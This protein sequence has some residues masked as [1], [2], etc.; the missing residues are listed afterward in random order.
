MKHAHSS[1]P[2]RTDDASNPRV[3]RR[4]VIDRQTTPPRVAAVRRLP[5]RPPRPAIQ[6]SVPPRTATR[7]PRPSTGR[8]S[9][10]S[11]RSP[12]GNV[13]APEAVRERMSGELPRPDSPRPT[14]PPDSASPRCRCSATMHPAHPPPPK[15][16]RRC[17]HHP[18]ASSPPRTHATRLG[19]R[20]EP[21][22]EVLDQAN[23]VGEAPASCPAETARAPWR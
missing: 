16:R 17:L 8:A 21:G 13:Q 3:V 2:N 4:A 22:H 12:D 19:C 1:R 15:R 18:Q 6:P 11:H 10:C 14:S 7:V 5:V 20:P 23:R 9:R